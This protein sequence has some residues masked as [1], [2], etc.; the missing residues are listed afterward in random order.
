MIRDILDGGH[1]VL[2]EEGDD[3]FDEE[4]EDRAYAPIG[5]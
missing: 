3:M 2:I 5:R 4:I 1:D